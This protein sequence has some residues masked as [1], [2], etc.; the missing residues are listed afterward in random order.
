MKLTL[1]IVWLRIIL[2]VM[3]MKSLGDMS[4]F[5]YNGLFFHFLPIEIGT[6]H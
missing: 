3:L 1:M 6:A 2:K 5:L 4:W